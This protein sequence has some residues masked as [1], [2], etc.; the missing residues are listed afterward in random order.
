MKKSIVTLATIALAAMILISCAAP[1]HLH[2]YCRMDS[3]C[4]KMSTDACSK[5]SGVEDGACAAEETFDRSQMETGE[6]EWLTDS[7][8][9]Q[10]YRTVKIGEQVWMAEN[11]NFKTNNS[12]CNGNKQENCDKYGR[13]YNYPEAMEACPSGW[14]LPNNEEWAALEKAIGSSFEETTVLGITDVRALTAGKILKS[15]SGWNH[16]KGIFSNDVVIFGNGTDDY[17]WTALPGG[18]LDM[19]MVDYIPGRGEVQIGEP[20][21]TSPGGY[22][23]WWSATEHPNDARKRFAYSRRI[24]SAGEIMGSRSGEH[25][26]N[27]LSVRCVQD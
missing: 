23:C 2:I 27:N 8:D 11:L 13:L 1:K 9:G 7:R 15:K 14:H 17:G 6:S 20:R 5:N 12:I 4:G 18:Y 24:S 25:R 16:T 3:V 22:G 21:F 26:A 19:P 10:K